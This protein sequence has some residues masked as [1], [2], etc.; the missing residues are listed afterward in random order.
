VNAFSKFI[1]RKTRLND[2]IWHRCF[3]K[4]LLL[5]LKKRG[6]TIDLQINADLQSMQLIIS[7]SRAKVLKRLYSLCQSPS[8]TAAVIPLFIKCF[9]FGA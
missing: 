3:L 4:L 6:Y 7:V 8:N 2:K 1:L 5:E 9:F